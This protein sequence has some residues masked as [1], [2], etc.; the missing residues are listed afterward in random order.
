MTP[1]ELLSHPAVRHARAAIHAR[2][3]QTL[4]EQIELVQ[5]PAPS[6]QEE[7]RAHE[8]LARFAAAGLAGT[9]IDEVGNVLGRLPAMGNGTPEEGAVVVCAHLDTVFPAGTDLSVRRQGERILAPGITDNARGLAAMLALV[10]VMVESGISTSRPLVF[11]ATVGEE[12]IG[13]LRGVKHLFRE[14]APL[15][16]ASACVALDG[17]GVRR[18]V[19]RAVGSRRLRIRILGPGGHSWADWGTANAVH[20]L[21]SAVAEMRALPLPPSPRTTLSVTRV[22]G[23]TSV[24]SIPAEAWLELD[25]RSEN[26]EA[27]ERLDGD[28][29]D[30]SQRAAAAENRQRRR[31]TG[32]LKVQVECIGDRPSGKTPAQAALV[33]AALAAT[34]AIG[35]RPMLVASSTDANVPIS[36]GIPAVTLGAGG[37]SGGIHTTEEWYSNEGGPEGIERALLTLLAV[38]GLI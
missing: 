25:I 24:N 35:E 18:I 8:V 4:R 2:D 28:A 30:T 29:R 17:S 20:A 38:A 32:A 3:T 7:E 31:G 6:L 9:R 14:G 34:R 10:R 12:G 33:R 11:A 5:I 15:H 27:L 13:D 23:G 36:L 21:A 26:Q 22:G 19:N 16:T 37:E 1:G